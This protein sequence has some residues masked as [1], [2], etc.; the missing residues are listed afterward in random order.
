MGLNTW[1]LAMALLR[2]IVEPARPRT[3]QMD[4]EAAKTGGVLA[5]MTY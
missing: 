4:T 5:A 1:S 3:Q 2:D